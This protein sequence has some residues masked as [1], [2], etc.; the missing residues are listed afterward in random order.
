MHQMI[1]GLR[2]GEMEKG[3]GFR[4]IKKL[5]ESVSLCVLCDVSQF[6]CGRVAADNYSSPCLTYTWALL[7]SL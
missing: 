4:K 3:Q 1:S 7:R 6:D 2:R 5:A